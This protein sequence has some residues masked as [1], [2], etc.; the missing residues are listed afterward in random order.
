MPTKNWMSSITSRSAPRQVRRKPGRPPPWS[1]CRKAVVNCSAES[2]AAV[3]EGCTS[4]MRSH[5][6][7]RRC[8]LP[9][10]LGPWTTSGLISPGRVTA[11]SMAPNA[12]RLL[13]PTM[14]SSRRSAARRAAWF[15]LATASRGGRWR[16]PAKPRSDVDSRLRRRRAAGTGA[17]DTAAGV[18]AGPT[19]A[20]A[21]SGSQITSAAGPQTSRTAAANSPRK[22][23]Q[24]HS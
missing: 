10:P 17:A 8:V 22:V 11:I 7:S 3:A 4:R 9:T 1:A 19:A 5:A 23:L 21:A 2:Q 6:P 18:T 16:P 14:K 13:G 24:S 20:S 12:M 15:G